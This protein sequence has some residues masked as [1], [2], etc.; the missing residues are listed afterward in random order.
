MTENEKD[1]YIELLR[2]DLI[3]KEKLIDELQTII[4]QLSTGGSGDIDIYLN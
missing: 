3:E 1:N 2:E 4:I